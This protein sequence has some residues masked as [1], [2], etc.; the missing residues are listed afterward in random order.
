MFHYF[1]MTKVYPKKT[2]DEIIKTYALYE[3]KESYPLGFI[4]GSLFLSFY[5]PASL[6]K[7]YEGSF[8]EGLLY[9]LFSFGG[10]CLFGLDIKNYFTVKKKEKEIERYIRDKFIKEEKSIKEIIDYL[11]ENSKEERTVTALSELEQKLK[12]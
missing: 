11:K 7:F 8:K 1:T 12:L 2:I 3:Y 4:S 6:V 9:A 10:A 5:L